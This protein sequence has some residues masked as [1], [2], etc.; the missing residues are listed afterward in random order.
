ML[1]LT[2]TCVLL[3]ASALALTGCGNVTE[4]ID[5][6]CWGGSEGVVEC[7]ITLKGSQVVTAPP[8]IDA[9]LA[10]IDLSQSNLSLV[11]PSGTFSILVKDSNGS[12]VASHVFG[13]Y[14]SGPYM[15]PQN[16]SQI[17][18]WI[19]SHIT[20]GDKAYFE[21]SGVSMNGNNGNNTA[22]AILEYGGESI[23]ASAS[24]YLND[25]DLN[26]F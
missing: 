11:S 23:G 3:F 16:P 4:H 5:I 24:F 14:K 13:W 26:G 12:V 6:D 15:L 25:A 17:S 8:N 18:S 10:R 9:S 20:S 21:F 19:N 2:K 1:K 7:N 22:V